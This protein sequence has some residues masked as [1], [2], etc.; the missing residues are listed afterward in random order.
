MWLIAE[1][2]EPARTLQETWNSSFRQV[3]LSSAAVRDRAPQL[4]ITQGTWPAGRSLRLVKASKLTTWWARRAIWSLQR[5]TI[6]SALWQQ[7]PKIR[8]IGSLETLSSN[9]WP[10]SSHHKEMERL[11]IRLSNR[12]NN[13]LRKLMLA[14]QVQRPSS[15]CR[16]KVICTRMVA[17]QVVT[18]RAWLT[19]LNWQV[20]V[21]VATIWSRESPVDVN[22]SSIRLASRRTLKLQQ[23]AGRAEHA[24]ARVT[25]VRAMR[26]QHH[27]L[28]Y[29]T[30]FTNSN[31]STSTWIVMSNLLRKSRSITAMAAYRKMSSFA[32]ILQSHSFLQ[33][34]KTNSKFIWTRMSLRI[35][36]TLPMWST[37]NNKSNKLKIVIFSSFWSPKYGK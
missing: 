11:W 5:Q 28:C 26:S 33:V 6:S 21:R 19:A 24:E 25:R 22:S 13:R 30:K 18:L 3:R 20:T 17:F 35:C 27:K 12:F 29:K 23:E 10:D 4:T 9:S 31:K 16:R 32:R 15:T 34:L 7:R 2:W 1:L 14:T 36:Q 8:I 37:N